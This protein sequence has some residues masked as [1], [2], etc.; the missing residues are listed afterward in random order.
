MK[1]F[2]MF[3]KLFFVLWSS[4]LIALSSPCA[5]EVAKIHVIHGYGET[6]EIFGTAQFAAEQQELMLKGTVELL[7]LRQR[8]MDVGSHTPQIN[9][10]DK[11][12]RLHLRD[13]LNT[14]HVSFY[15]D[16]NYSKCSNALIASQKEVFEAIKKLEDD[17]DDIFQE[18]MKI[19]DEN[20]KRKQDED[21]DAEVAAAAAAAAA[22]LRKE[23]DE[24]YEAQRI[25]SEAYHRRV[26]KAQEILQAEQ[27]E[28]E[29]IIQERNA[30]RLRKL[31]AF[32]AR[33]MASVV[34]RLQHE[35]NE[36]PKDPYKIK[37]ITR[38]GIVR[39]LYC[40]PD[41]CTPGSVILHGKLTGMDMGV[42]LNAYAKRLKVHMADK[43]SVAYFSDDLGHLEIETAFNAVE[44][45]NE[46][47]RV[48]NVSMDILFEYPEADL[49]ESNDPNLTRSKS[50]PK[51]VVENNKKSH[52]KVIESSHVN[53]V[54]SADGDEP[55]DDQMKCWSCE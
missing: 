14:G 6:H 43:K 42:P 12:K 8:T 30:R 24:A 13:K 44:I 40:N 51:S 18:M 4:L 46:V 19:S 27:A 29:K 54:L 39:T 50:I 7:E 21:V 11:Y 35:F 2:H 45:M 53:N 23:Q 37:S 25:K 26:K 16:D 41:P 38:D 22:A 52:T 28:K 34:L 3:K 48:Q 1:D 20:V 9:L 32:K 49:S 36:G 5:A 17:K 31:L 47:S 33:Y 55:H 10:Y 15:C